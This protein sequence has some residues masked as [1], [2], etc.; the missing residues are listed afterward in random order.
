MQQRF[1]DNG[2]INEDPGF[3]NPDE[4]DFRLA[5]NSP[6]LDAGNPH[7]FY[8]DADGS[9]ND[10]GASGGNDLLFGFQTN[11]EFPHTSEHSWAHDN[12]VLC[13]VN[14]DPIN[15]WQLSL[16][17]REN[18]IVGIEAPLN[19]LP[20]QW[21][22]FPLDFHP[23]QP[24]EHEATLTFRFRDYPLIEEA[25][26]SMTG[27]SLDGVEGEVKGV[28]TREMSP[29]HV[30][31]DVF[32]PHSDTLRIEPGVEVRFDPGTRLENES[33]AYGA[34]YAIGTVEDSIRFT[35]SQEDPNLSYWVLLEIRGELQ[36]CVVEYAEM[37]IWLRDGLI[38]HSTF[39]NCERGIWVF[40]HW[41]PGMVRN[42]RIE[43]CG[44][45]ID[46]DPTGTIEYSTITHCTDAIYPLDGGF[47]YHNLFAFNDDVTIAHTYWAGGGGAEQEIF[48]HLTATGNIF[49]HNG[50]VS[51]FS[52]DHP[53]FRYNCMFESEIEGEG[54]LIG[55]LNRENF[56]GTPC[57][58]NFNI[59]I[60]PEFIDADNLDF[61]L[62]EDSPCIDA[63]DPDSPEDPDETRADIGA[64]YFHQEE[65]DEREIHLVGHCDTPDI[66]L[67]VTVQGD[68]A[69]VAD[70][71]SGLRIIDISNPEEPDEIGYYDTPGQ[72]RDVFVSADY[73]Y[74]ADLGSGLRVISITDPEHPEEVGSYETPRTACGI[75]ISGDYAYIADHSR[76]LRVID[77]SNPENPD[78][79]GHWDTPEPGE[80]YG[81][82]VSGNNAYVANN[83]L[84]LS[85]LSIVDPENPEEIGHYDTPDY[86]QDVTVSGDYAYIADFESGL[87]VI[88]VSD[89]EN[90]EEVGYFDTPGYAGSVTVSGDHAYIADRE[91][92]LRVI[93]VA[94]PENPVEVTSYDTDG[95]AYDVFISGDNAYVADMGNGLVILDISDY[96][97]NVT[98]SLREG[99]NMMSLNVSPAQEFYREG[100][101]QGPDVP[102]LLEQLR[103]DD[104]NH[105]VILAK[106]IRGHF[107]SP[108][109]DFCNIPYWDLTNGY[110]IKMF[111]DFS[112]VW[113]GAPIP[114]DADLPLTEGWN[115]IAYYPQYDL[116]SS[117]PDFYVL[118]P[119]IDQVDIAKD[120]RG[121]FMSPSWDF[122]NMP[123]WAE[124]NGYLVKVEGD[125]TLN[126]PPEQEQ[127]A[128]LDSDNPRD[129][130]FTVHS[131]V[132]M[133][134]LVQFP[135]AHAGKVQAIDA[136]GIVVGAG[137]IDDDG[138]CG[139]A[140]W[141][142]DILTAEREG[143]TA[144]EAFSLNLVDSGDDVLPLEVGSIL[145]GDG[146]VYQTDAFVAIDAVVSAVIPADYSLSA[147]YPNP[148]N[149]VTRLTYGLP[150]AGRVSLSVFDI[151]GRQ[152]ATLF[153]GDQTA[154]MHS[155]SWNAEGM[156]SGL[157]I[158]RM[159]AA[160]GSYD[161]KVL[162]MK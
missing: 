91:G 51:T 111:C 119:I 102:L 15:L 118:S 117:D 59:I 147:A 110:L 140:V 148:F 144:G 150:L 7:P 45:G 141:G 69:Y 11:I 124:T 29:I 109:H 155:V 8:T 9:R 18:F 103:I 93:S 129:A 114:E 26:I 72:A 21:I 132:N 130:A 25:V 46:V 40:T 35:S 30:V 126:Y 94:D 1:E 77:I 84:G 57:D 62:T 20:Y 63:G 157:Y 86:A 47:A 131:P 134:L 55:E 58:E 113:T 2:N 43:N 34:L 10:I 112:P 74:I 50:L 121:R 80:V 82:T 108:R 137:F 97:R 71:R 16:S 32:I 23:I 53:A 37:G 151:S 100:E 136:S 54:V 17:D 22:D 123:P 4:F 19:L 61:H 3:V 41:E 24:G 143:L 44:L 122:S 27:T 99:W 68:Y 78:E 56:N 13:N 14:D 39:R 145:A 12:L 142:D 120:I 106:D 149:A 125:V 159:S 48:V 152:I 87:R 31:G 154:G 52:R 158:V 92:G 64:F 160:A 107:Y 104:H 79:V 42:C 135:T 83:Y 5:E 76:G 49:Y 66:A 156:P 67:S 128:A 36:Y 98:V 81:V 96:N 133:S 127:V 115:M 116:D 146:L 105:H 70:Y 28:W 73:A 90:P 85:V 153:N 75:S 6:A 139:V 33:L 89:P 88:E 101:D 161:V 60:D 138:R 95:W 38:E 162:L 65:E